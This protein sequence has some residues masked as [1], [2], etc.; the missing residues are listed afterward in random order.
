MLHL[1]NLNRSSSDVKNRN[2]DSSYRE[3]LKLEFSVCH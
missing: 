3:K 1:L 2:E